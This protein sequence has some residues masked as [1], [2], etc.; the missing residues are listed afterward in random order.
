MEEADLAKTV[1]K[2]ILQKGISS[3]TG[4]LR[5]F[6]HEHLDTETECLE[7]N[8]SE[9][10]GEEVDEGEDDES[11]VVQGNLEFNYEDWVSKLKTLITL[12]VKTLQSVGEVV[13]ED[14]LKGVLGDQNKII[15]YNDE[16]VDD[17]EESSDE[18][19]EENLQD[20]DKHADGSSEAPGDQAEEEEIDDGEDHEDE[21][22]LLEN[23][24]KS[25]KAEEKGQEKTVSDQLNNT[26]GLL[27][28]KI[29]ELQTQ[30]EGIETFTSRLQ[31]CSKELNMA[32]SQPSTSQSNKQGSLMNA[33]GKISTQIQDG[34][35]D[36]VFMNK[37]VQVH[38]IEQKE[39]MSKD[40]HLIKMEDINKQ[41]PFKER[42]KMEF[43][44]DL[45]VNDLITKTRAFNSIIAFKDENSFLAVKKSIGMCLKED[46][47]EIYS[48]NPCPQNSKWK[49]SVY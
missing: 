24:K 23:S 49:A 4:L 31:T 42:L 33:L 36:K 26:S 13:S 44:T 5:Y 41:K 34:S 25:L 38:L 32:V 6:D 28:E 3:I 30:I 2:Q 11:E 35:Q 39:I 15:A 22:N 10:E 1:K 21:N 19:R 46:D 45:P 8:N 37:S 20:E 40:E 18:D 29:K 14:D 12:S 47:V 48:S 16:E 9:E 7:K 27:T 17:K 43:E